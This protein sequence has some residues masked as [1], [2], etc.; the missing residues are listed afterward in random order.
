M[1]SARSRRAAAAGRP[2]CP[3]RRVLIVDDTPQNVD[4]VQ[5]ILGKMELEYAVAVNGKEAVEIAQKDG[6]FGLILMDMKMPVMDGYEATRQLRALGVTTP[7]IGV[8][9]QAM[10]GDGKLCLDAG[11]DRYITK[12]LKLDEF[13]KVLRE[14]TESPNAR[15]QVS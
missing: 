8:T 6:P 15:Q 14:Y 11:C 4:L 12:P 10:E 9:A 5:R 7:I 13:V 3:C 1:T 2:D